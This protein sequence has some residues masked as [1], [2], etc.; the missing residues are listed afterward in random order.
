MLPVTVWKKNTWK[1]LHVLA[2]CFLYFSIFWS[3]ELKQL[4]IDSPKRY[5]TSLAAFFFL[6]YFWCLRHIAMS[7]W[8]SV[9]PLYIPICSYTFRHS[10]TTNPEKAFQ[11]E[12]SGRITARTTKVFKGPSAMPYVITRKRL[13][14]LVL[15]QDSLWQGMEKILAQRE[16]TAF[17]C[18]S[19]SQISWGKL[20]KCLELS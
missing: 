10:E 12:H 5:R 19:Q 8:Y 7:S 11:P 15:K 16:P 9:Q 17:R 6:G 18:M 3:A 14:Q 4:L 2:W 20:P 1:G 13:F